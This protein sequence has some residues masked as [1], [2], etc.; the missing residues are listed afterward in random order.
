[1]GSFIADILTHHEER[2]TICS[3]CCR[4]RKYKKFLVSVTQARLAVML[5]KA[6]PWKASDDG[7][8]GING[9]RT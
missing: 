9:R 5:V 6:K 2:A 8:I 7:F 4:V 3:Y 1:M